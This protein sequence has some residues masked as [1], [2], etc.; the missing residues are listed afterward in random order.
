MPVKSIS[1]Q[2]STGGNADIHDIT[3]QVVYQVAQSGLKDGTVTVFCPSSTSAVTTI[4]YESGALS[5][6]RRSF[7]EIIPS[8]REY[9]HNARWGDGNGHSHVRASL[10]GPSLTIP[11]VNGR[12]TLGTWQQIIYVDFDNRPRKRELIL[13]LMGE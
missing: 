5:D 9:A 2:L 8:N 10:L 11:F 3:E 4:E 6:L 13:Q 1:F 12:L 7:D